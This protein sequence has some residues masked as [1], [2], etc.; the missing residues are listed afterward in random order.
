ME[1]FLKPLHISIS[2]LSKETG[3]SELTIDNILNGKEKITDE[4]STK[5]GNFFGVYES[6]FFN[7]QKDIDKRNNK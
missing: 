7:I 2:S 3:I 6:Y 4:I 5:L 1:E